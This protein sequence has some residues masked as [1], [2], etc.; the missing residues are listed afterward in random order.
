MILSLLL[1][2]VTLTFP[3]EVKVQ[4]TEVTVNEVAR[5]TGENVEEVRRVGAVDLGYAPMPGHSRLFF[6]KR[7][8]EIIKRDTGIEVTLAGHRAC[9]AWPKEITI[10]GDQI[11]DAARVELVRL[12]TEL[13]AEYVLQQQQRS[14]SVPAGNT[15]IKLEAY[16]ENPKVQSGVISV[17]VRILVDNQVYRTVWT[18][19]SVNVYELRTVL[20]KP[21]AAGEMLTPKHFTQK[22]ALVPRIG[23]ANPLGRHLAIGAVATRDLKPGDMVTNLDVNRPMIIHRGDT[24]YLQARSR[25]ITARVPAKAEED[26]ALGDRIRVSTL[27]GGR[28]LGAVVKSRDLVEVVLSVDY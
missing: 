11:E 6:G 17:P 22:R 20:I 12:T 5:I 28:Q 1:T 19:W 24:I 4:G 7:V 8:A 14:I 2:G 25:S 10:T 16:F 9:R 23:G 13:D 21:V 3:M 15:D 18:R 27:E 26:G